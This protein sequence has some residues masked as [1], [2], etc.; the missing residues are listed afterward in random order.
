[1]LLSGNGR[2]RRPRPAPRLVVAAGV[3]GA[4]VALPLVSAVGAHAATSGTWDKVALCESG[5]NWSLNSGNGSYGGLQFTQS[6]WAHYGGKRFAPRPDLASRQEQIAVGEKVLADQG[7]GAW[8]GCGL[9]AGLAKGGPAP[10]VPRPGQPGQLGEHEP[11]P[12]PA[13]SAPTHGQSAGSSRSSWGPSASGTSP[14]PSFSPSTSSSG[15]TSGSP[16]ASHGRKHAG[17]SADETPS[18][19]ASGK[20]G[21]RHRADLDGNLLPGLPTDGG[22]APGTEP[23]PSATPSRSAQDG[24]GAQN[25]QGAA[26]SHSGNQYGLALGGNLTRIVQDAHLILPLQ[27]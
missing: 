24:Q 9:R 1:M 10:E 7:P 5:D 19:D 12:G 13:P 14:G 23:T 15:R 25:A 3:T 18:A 16:G 2:H 11:E 27:P 6:T 8:P 21:G 26:G 22:T 17:P 4:G 20:R